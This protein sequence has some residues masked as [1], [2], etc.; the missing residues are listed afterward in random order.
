M[1][2]AE[3]ACEVTAYTDLAV[4]PSTAYASSVVA[5][6]AAFNRSGAATANVTTAAYS[7]SS[8]GRPRGLGH[9]SER[10]AAPALGE[11]CSPQS[12][13]ARR[14]GQWDVAYCRNSN[15]DPARKTGSASAQIQATSRIASP[16]M[17]S[18]RTERTDASFRRRQATMPRYIPAP[19][20]RM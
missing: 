10:H 9:R 13:P 11:Y 17:R 5:V 18:I 16:G 12:G 19:P 14:D 6:D 20:V 8:S 4:A 1:R 15:R 2:V 3:V 7:G